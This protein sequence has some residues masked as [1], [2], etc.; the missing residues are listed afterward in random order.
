MK[1]NLTCTICEKPIAPNEKY[2]KDQINHG[3]NII[4]L[5]NNPNCITNDR[6]NYTNHYFDNYQNADHIREN[7]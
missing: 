4:I 1:N 3:C 7:F 2:Y 6:N 5:C